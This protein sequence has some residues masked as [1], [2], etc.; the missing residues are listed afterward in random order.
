M[1]A[2]DRDSFDGT[3]V[4]TELEA[5]CGFTPVRTQ[6]ALVA[7]ATDG[8]L[9][10]QG[11]DAGRAPFEDADIS[12]IFVTFATTVAQYPAAT[13]ALLRTAV[14]SAL[15]GMWTAFADVLD[16]P[17]DEVVN[18]PARL[19]FHLA[20][21]GWGFEQARIKFKSE[22]PAGEFCGL[23]WLVLNGASDAPYSFKID[24]K[25]SVEANYDYALF[26]QASQDA[27]NQSTRVIIDP[28]IEVIP[29]P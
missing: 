24:A 4:Q 25:C 8:F 21:P 26:I 23:E 15:S 9:V 3:V 1:A 13:A 17:F 5:S 20:I 28:K 22:L 10:V 12:A 19:I 6:I 7:Q 14:L 18:E 11:S 2:I 29:G 27:G 16:S